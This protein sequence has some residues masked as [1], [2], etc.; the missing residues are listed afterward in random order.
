MKGRSKMDTNQFW[1]TERIEKL[2]RKYAVPVFLVLGI[3]R[4]LQVI[5]YKI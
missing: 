5:F 3:S 1:G 2:M 4:F